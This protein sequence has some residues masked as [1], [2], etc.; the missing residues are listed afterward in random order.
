M[1]RAHLAFALLGFTTIVSQDA[2]AQSGM[3]TLPPPG[4]PPGAPA[5]SGAVHPAPA[6]GLPAQPG[7]QPPRTAQPGQPP[8]A[9]PGIIP[10]GGRSTTQPN[11]MEQRV[12]RQVNQQNEGDYGSF[13]GARAGKPLG[14]IQREWDNPK[15]APGQAS[16]GYVRV[17]W[18]PGYVIRVNTRDFMVTTIQL[19][20][21]ETIIDNG[22]V[23]G[24]PATFEAKR[25]GRNVLFVRPTNPGADTNMTVMTEGGRIYSFYI[26][27]HGFNTSVITDLIVEVVPSATPNATGAYAAADDT[28]TSPIVAAS[29]STGPGVP[30]PHGRSNRGIELEYLRSIATKPE[31]LDFT[32]LQ[33]W[34]PSEPDKEIA[35]AR[36]FT[37]GIFTYF[38]FGDKGDTVMRPI[39]RRIIDGVDTVVNTRT[40]GTR[41]EILVAEGVGNFTLRNG[42]RI[43][44]IRRVGEPPRAALNTTTLNKGQPEKTELPPRS[45]ASSNSPNPFHWVSRQFN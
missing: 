7:Q 2:L 14:T 20:E 12:N 19:P 32:T 42:N 35:P 6:P 15:P 41:G 16:P 25:A 39:V 27:S 23:I 8:G 43:V 13:D 31:N 30:L 3:V 1:R 22:A 5:A 38:D 17:S 11:P 26:R 9:S 18:R 37:D 44:C 34:A 36:V 24:D 45:G 40:V 33:M 28:N 29:N 10:G 21:H 4:S